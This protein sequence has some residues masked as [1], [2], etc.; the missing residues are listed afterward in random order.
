M[1]KQTFASDGS[2]ME[3][4]LKMQSEQALAQTDPAAPAAPI[5]EVL[6]ASEPSRENTE[7][8]LIC[9]SFSGQ[10]PGF[11]FKCGCKGLGYYKDSPPLTATGQG[12]VAKVPA[13][14]MLKSNRSIARVKG[15]FPEGGSETKKQKKKRKKL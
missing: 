14:V 4:F 9:D 1:E 8:F 10:K 11:V 5:I 2:F 15:G 12:V 7:D 3:L 13:P 6:A